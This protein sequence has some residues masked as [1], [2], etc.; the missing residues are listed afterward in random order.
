VTT[1][2]AVR[3]AA[4][5]TAIAAC[6]AF[7]GAARSQPADASPVPPFSRALPG[8]PFPA[9]W[10]PLTF[11]HLPRHTSYAL[12]RDAEAGVVVRAEADASASGLVVRLDHDAADRSQLAWRWK[13]DRPILR[14]D[15]TRR[16][17]D[18][19]PVRIYVAFKH[20]PE[21]VSAFERARHTLIT[22]LYGEP[23]PHAALNYIWDARSPVGT[24]VPN[25][26]TARVRMVVVESGTARL[27]RWLAYERDVL[28]DYRA[29]F[30]EEPPP[31]SGI[32]IMSDADD[33][34][35]SALAWYGDVTLGRR[36]AN[37]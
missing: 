13:V 31:I 12:V 9:G 24:V 19:Y 34:G 18:D 29:A 27:G 2:A 15:V 7:A 10:V 8:G 30:G 25:P 26:Y 5:A 20:V 35:E 21:R 16:A 3:T 32:G 33:T 14:S 37:P 6:A 17:G 11:P 22:L 4:L 28:A 1:R 23:P 36:R